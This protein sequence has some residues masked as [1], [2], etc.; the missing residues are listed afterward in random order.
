M[1]FRFEEYEKLSIDQLR[2]N[3]HQVYAVELALDGKTWAGAESILAE[4][5]ACGIPVSK[6]MATHVPFSD[7]EMERDALLEALRKLYRRASG[8]TLCLPKAG[9]GAG[10]YGLPIHSPKIYGDLC[11]ILADYFGYIQPPISATTLHS[12]GGSSKPYHHR[13]FIEVCTR[14]GVYMSHMVA[15][16]HGL[17]EVQ[18]KAHCLV[19]GYE[20]DAQG[21]LFPLH[22]PTYRWANGE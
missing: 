19:A 2:A 4:P 5:N 14:G 18:L 21:L 9:I 10:P 15:E 3:P 8:R 22:L 16:K 1:R 6:A 13:L 12:D 17:T 11:Q 20:L 7:Q